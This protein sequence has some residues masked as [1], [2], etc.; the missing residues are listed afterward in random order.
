MIYWN[1]IQQH[2]ASI[3]IIILKPLPPPQIL[4]PIIE[5]A[6]ELITTA[7]WPLFE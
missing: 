3:V 1:L 7:T 6:A 5:N 2:S 4:T